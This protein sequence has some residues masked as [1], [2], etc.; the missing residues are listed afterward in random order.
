MLAERSPSP[1]L[2]EVE[3]INGNAA[4]L[5]LIRSLDD[6]DQNVDAAA[7]VDPI[8]FAPSPISEHDFWRVILKKSINALA[9]GISFGLGAALVDHCFLRK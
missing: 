6:E 1:T 8:F 3:N 4:V 5:A 7:G 2:I 9:A